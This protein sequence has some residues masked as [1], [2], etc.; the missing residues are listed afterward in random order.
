MFSKSCEYAIKA[1]VYIAQQSLQKRRVR[2]NDI[3]KEINSPA[4][5]T[6]KIL[7]LLAKEKIIHS[8]MGQIGG[9]E[10]ELSQLDKITLLNI[11]N[12]IDGEH[13]HSGCGLGL[14]ECNEL[15]PCPIHSDF[16]KIR[17]DLKQM[18]NNTTILALAT[19]LDNGLVHLT[20]LTKTN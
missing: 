4:A 11:V 20:R 3:A 15:I 1:V 13:I 16:V 7:Q 18:L 5:F 9:Y 19:N 6:A 14:K 17:D 12:T 2:L 8:V 10:I